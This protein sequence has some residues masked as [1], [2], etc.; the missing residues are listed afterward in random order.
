MT[1]TS[2]KSAPLQVC[3]RSV[4]GVSPDIFETAGIK[5]RRLVSRISTVA[6]QMKGARRSTTPKHLFDGHGC[7]REDGAMGDLDEL[8]A[9]AHPI[10][11]QLLSLVTGSAMS[12][13]EAA[14]ELG[15]TQANASYHLRLLERA[16]LVRV[17]ETARIRGGMA[18]RYRHETSAQP[19][20]VT[21]S[22]ESSSEATIG[23]PAD[24]RVQFASVLSNELRRRVSSRST[25]PAVWTDAELWV[26]PEVWE[27]VVL[28]VGDAA[29]LLHASAQP[30]RSEGAGRVAM[31]TAL[32]TMA[33]Q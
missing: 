26:S 23:T 15:I 7:E 21:V 28:L 22:T 31:T 16:G 13:A 30:A 6:L 12:S 4:P 19:F 11:L 14:R 1:F 10:R 5:L 8:R 27:R 25:G 3:R 32:F 18:K 29:A 2:S 24:A 17:V 9:T 33:S 20:E